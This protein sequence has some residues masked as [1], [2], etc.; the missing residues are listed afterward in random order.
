MDDHDNASGPFPRRELLIVIPPA[1]SD[2]MDVDALIAGLESNSVLQL[3]R[4]EVAGV[5]PGSNQ[6][7]GA[8]R[9]FAYDQENVKASGRSLCPSFWLIRIKKIQY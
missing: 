2:T 4:K 9:T 6:A 8:A 5:R 3:K 7:A 1:A